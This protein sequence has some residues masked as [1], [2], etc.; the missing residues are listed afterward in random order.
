MR[1]GGFN[2][3]QRFSS[4]SQEEEKKV[5]QEARLGRN[6]GD[7]QIKGGNLRTEVVLVESRNTSRIDRQTRFSVSKRSEACS[8]EER[9]PKFQD[10]LENSRAFQQHKKS[11]D[12]QQERVS[13]RQRC[14]A[15]LE[16]RKNPTVESNLSGESR[17]AG[18]T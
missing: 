5:Q 1:S 11:E 3:G 16:M 18:I 12:K 13:Q 6:S 2:P 9:G 4:R 10:R 17:V 15:R 14:D 7:R 8:V